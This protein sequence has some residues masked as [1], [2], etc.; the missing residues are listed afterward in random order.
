M[1]IGYWRGFLSVRNLRYEG[2]A[3]SLESITQQ[4]KD[5]IEKLSHV[6]TCFSFIKTRND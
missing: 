1:A 3:M 5:E 6:L 2:E 4:V